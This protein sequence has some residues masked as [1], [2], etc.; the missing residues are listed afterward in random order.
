MRALQRAGER[1]EATPE[2]DRVYRVDEAIKFLVHYVV[3]SIAIGASALNVRLIASLPALLEPF[4]PLSPVLHAM[5]QNTLATRDSTCHGRFER[6]RERWLALYEQLAQVTGQDLQYVDAVRNA[7]AFALG[8][9]EAQLG[10]ESAGG[11]A[12]ILDRDPAQR[13]NAMYLRKAVCMQHGDFVGAE[14]FR[15][16]AEVLALQATAP[17]MF[18]NM[19]SVE[20]AI[21]AAA[22]DLTGVKRVRDRIE[23]LAAKYPGWRAYAHLADAQFQRLRGDLEGACAALERAFALCAPDASDPDRLLQAWPRVASTYIEVLVE[24]ERY[25]EARDFGQRTLDKCTELEIVVARFDIERA[26]ALAEAGLKDRSGAEARLERLIATQCE[27]GVA[28]LN[29][30]LSFEARARIAIWA[31]DR[32]AVEHYAPLAAREYRHG[33]GSS[34]G[35]RYERLMQEARATGIRTLPPARELAHS[36]LGPTLLGGERATLETTITEALSV[37]EGP[38]ALVQRALGLL[39][40]AHKAPGGHLYVMRDAN[41]VHAAT[42]GTEPPEENL[43]SLVRE[44]WDRQLQ[45]PEMATAILPQNGPTAPSSDTLWTDTA[46]TTQR[47]LLLHCVLEGSV[48]HVGVAV[49]VAD[50]P[51]WSSAN[52]VVTTVAAYLVRA[53]AAAGVAA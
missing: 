30:G 24:Q 32:A 5:W 25:A 28:G 44:F 15:R 38:E 22:R 53:G 11:W 50:S 14:G 39:C 4:A 41:L 16:K 35:A 49:L 37:T 29:L 42:H 19:T 2:S 21:H 3:C 17:Q 34:L 8:I 1:Y 27:L 51:A 10:L 33:R 12:A 20:L 47:P 13:V 36:V 45:D 48:K 43:L 31:G 26:M 40:A 18:A 9:L 7:V 46:G 6:A 23:P 52:E